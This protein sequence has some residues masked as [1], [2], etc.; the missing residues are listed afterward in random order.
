M[1]FFN[2][3]DICVCVV[4]FLICFV[5]SDHYLRAL[6]SL[7]AP[8]IGWPMALLADIAWPMALLAEHEGKESMCKYRI[9]A[10]Q[11]GHWFLWLVLA[12]PD[13]VITS[14]FRVSWMSILRHKIPCSTTCSF[15]ALLKTECAMG[16]REG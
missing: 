7:E 9:L 13:L 8:L 3:I 14:A 5:S 16:S 2:V 1:A 6:F 10:E 12:R 15:V 4:V 11:K